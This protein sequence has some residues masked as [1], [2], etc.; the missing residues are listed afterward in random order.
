MADV[1]ARKLRDESSR[2]RKDSYVPADDETKEQ[3]RQLLAGAE[4]MAQLWTTDR[5]GGRLGAMVHLAVM[6]A[7]HAAG[8]Y[9][10]VRTC[11]AVHAGQCMHSSTDVSLRYRRCARRQYVQASKL[12]LLLL[13][14]CCYSAAAAT[15]LL[16]LLLLLLCA[17]HQVLG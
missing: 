3:A 5:E 1:Y 15:L 7:A 9:N 16:L 11:N 17:G 6:S 10:K 12:L 4:R 13:C 2:G 8:K 14:C